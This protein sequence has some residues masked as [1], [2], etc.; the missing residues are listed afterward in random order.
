MLVSKNTTKSAYFTRKEVA[1]LL[2]VHPSTVY[3]WSKAKLIPEPIVLGPN[4]T[5]WKVAEVFEWMEDCEKNRGFREV[6]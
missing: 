5:V 6:D 2:G 1:R 4:Q 3:R